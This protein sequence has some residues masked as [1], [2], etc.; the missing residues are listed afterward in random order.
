MDGLMTLWRRLRFL[1]DRSRRDAELGD[2]LRFHLDQR[3]AELV[4]D[5]VPAAEAA[6]IARRRFGNQT[7]IR[8]EGREAWISRALDVTARDV[9][10]A[11]RGLR[12]APGFALAALA[13]L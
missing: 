11:L 8:Q 10:V 5:G 6:R 12:R 7:A 13:T 9:R 2:E 3:V 1:L 4:K